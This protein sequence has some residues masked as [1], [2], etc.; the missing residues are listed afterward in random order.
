[1][2]DSSITFSIKPKI[3][4]EFS[5]FHLFLPVFVRCDHNIVLQIKT[6]QFS[7]YIMQKL[8][9]TGKNTEINKYFDGNFWLN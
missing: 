4:I 3:D 9:K 8:V 6:K 5:C 2:R 7:D 1:M